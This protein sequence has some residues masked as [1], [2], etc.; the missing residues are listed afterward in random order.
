MRLRE[1]HMARVE[2]LYVRDGEDRAKSFKT[3]HGEYAQILEP[4]FVRYWLLN[5]YRSNQN[6]DNPAA[7]NTR[8]APSRRTR[9]LVKYRFCDDA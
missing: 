9:A 3:F 4:D 7:A 6:L 5:R 2:E 8:A 1:E